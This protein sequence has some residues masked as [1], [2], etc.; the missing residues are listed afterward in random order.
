M[1]R[2]RA[3]GLRERPLGSGSSKNHLWLDVWTQSSV[4][5][6]FDRMR[7]KESSR[8]QSNWV[9][10]TDI[11]GIL[12]ALMLTTAPC[13]IRMYHL[14][15]RIIQRACDE[16]GLQSKLKM[17]PG[18][19]VSGFESWRIGHPISKCEMQQRW[20]ERTGATAVPQS[21]NRTRVNSENLLS[22]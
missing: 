10:L 20:P 13:A 22:V 11:A 7:G 12:A 17:W 14:T 2:L 1:T 4:S 5:L 16:T 9:A 15:R 21:N 19:A 8:P 3:V 6:R 18:K